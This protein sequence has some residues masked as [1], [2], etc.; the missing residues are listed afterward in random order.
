M[1][2]L[3]AAA[4]RNH[5]SGNIDQ[6]EQQYYEILKLMPRHQYALHLLG[7]LR[8]QKGRHGDAV[9]L[10]RQ[11]IEIQATSPMFSHLALALKAMGK[12]NEAE[13][14]LCDCLA[15]A[16]DDP[17]VCANLGNLLRET[18]R[19]EEAVE[20]CQQAIG[21][22]PDLMEAHNN[23][24]LAFNELGRYKA[25]EASFRKAVAI[26]P[27]YAECQFNL[28]SAL[29]LQG[30]LEEA[31]ASYER[32]VQI[33]PLLV[34]ARFALGNIHQIQGH[35][36][37]AI[38]QFSKVLALQ[39][40]HKEAIYNLAWAL[41]SLARIDEAIEAYCRVLKLD[42][43]YKPA[44]NNLGNAL[45]E[46]GKEAD[47]AV[48]FRKILSI[49]QDDAT[50]HCNLGV[51]L[52]M[53]GDLTGALGCYKAALA[54]KPDYVQAYSNL[55]VIQKDL[56]DLDSAVIS[57]RYALQIRPDDIDTH[58]NLLFCL[59]QSPACTSDK[60]VEEARRYGSQLIKKTRPYTSW[61]SAPTI[62]TKNCLRLGFVSGDLKNHPVGF[63]LEGLL[64]QLDRSRFETIAY[65]TSQFSDVMTERI[66]QNFNGWR[67][68]AGMANEA[69]A[70]MIHKDKVDI[71]ID[72]AGHTAYNRLPIFAWKPAP[73]QVTWLGYFA[74][75]GVPRM[76]Y[77]LA[78]ERSVPVSQRPFFTEQVWRLPHTR[79]CFT[80]PLE[81]NLLPV[82]QLPA[83][84]NGTIQFGSNQNLA[85]IND[86]VLALWSRAMKN[87]TGSTLRLQNKQLTDA[88]VRTEFLQ[89]L[90][91]SGID[92]RRV[93][94]ENPMG[95]GAYLQSHDK[96]DMILDTFPFPGG[97]TTCEALWMG[98]PT[99]TLKGHSLLSRQGESLMGC[100][101]LEDWIATDADDYV[102]RAV[103]FSSDIVGLEHLR[104][105]LRPRIL[106][107][108][109]CDARQFARDFETALWGMWD[110]KMKKGLL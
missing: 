24:G 14:A 43:N 75:T 58:S 3:L 7:V 38:K 8:Y 110:G 86:G 46:K 78:D 47:A 99:L 65:V 108:P 48:C 72:L 96:I 27:D 44:L 63:F 64:L 49:Q 20:Y 42:P 39:P 89:R 23:L 74:S 16:P 81:A 56:G 68:I 55:G 28:G 5:Q 90:A 13:K 41:H 18:G 97:T 21:L 80:P 100:A 98:V 83:I 76:D 106:S 85:K 11:A 33:D 40:N 92:E 54:L 45:L 37:D 103:L 71:L 69:A 93:I 53:A 22:K 12:L 79:L 1:T 34:V 57:F 52:K 30:C 88:H 51:A 59:T 84:K 101:G 35:R 31:L 9:K 25:A 82:S 29:Q 61:G 105:N 95:R 87:V 91:R 36:E 67:S 15:L 4:V 70:Q 26:R 50:A 32:A 73:V 77:L 60:Y 17:A 107:S 62:H 66:K 102:K 19:Y 94:I 2:D 109:L 104:Q 10:I 6:A